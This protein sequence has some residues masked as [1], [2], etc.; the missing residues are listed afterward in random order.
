M[1]QQTSKGANAKK[2]LPEVKGGLPAGPN[3]K[4]EAPKTNLPPADGLVATGEKKPK[5]LIEG[6]TRGRMPIAVVAQ[7]RFGDNKGLENKELADLYGTTI[8]KIVDIKKMATFAYVG[9]DF[10]PTEAQKVE[11]IAWLQRHVAFKEGKVDKLIS[12]LEATK[13]ATAAEATAL[14]TARVAAKGQKSTTKD[15]AVADG[16][17]GNRVK[18]AKPAAAPAGAKPSGDALLK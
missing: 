3:G 13:V 18:P 11:G 6:I 10:K 16:G 1:G 17:G 12:E 2:E 9:A 8:G 15:G 4:P 7:V 5:V 14:E